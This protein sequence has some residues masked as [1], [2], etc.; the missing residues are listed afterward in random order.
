MSKLDLNH[1]L[2]LFYIKGLIYCIHIY[3][4]RIL[5]AQKRK[6]EWDILVC[7]EDII[8]KGGCYKAYFSTKFPSLSIHFNPLPPNPPSIPVT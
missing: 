5:N 6:I 3:L 1:I 8:I 7:P 2:I 4:F